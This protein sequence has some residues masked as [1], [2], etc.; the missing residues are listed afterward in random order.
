MKFL[1]V[2]LSSSSKRPSTYA[3]LSEDRDLLILDSFRE[4]HELPELLESHDS[5]LTAIDAPL[6]LPLGT[7]CL[8]EACPCTPVL[9]QK[10]RLAE[11]E[12]SK[13]RIGCF[14]TSKRS[15]IKKLI[16]R[17]VS[18]YKKLKNNGH[19]VI[20][21]Y[22]YAT[23]VMLFGDGIPAKNSRK[24]L[25]FMKARVCELIPD[26]LPHINTLNHQKCDALIAAYTASLDYRNETDRL[27]NEQ[28]GYVI[29]PKLTN[30]NGQGKALTSTS[31]LQKA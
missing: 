27:G 4:D 5:P 12:L 11:L 15:I 31:T 23:K 2:D 21:V 8:E 17:A 10:G 1:G 25:D 18:Q 7:D 13:M 24:G 14:F 30:R 3:L 28:E 19:Q 6:T 9:N 20:E 22:P 16:Y 29:V 26:A